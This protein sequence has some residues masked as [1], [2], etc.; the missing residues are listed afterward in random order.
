MLANRPQ[1]LNQCVASIGLRAQSRPLVIEPLSELS[2]L[3]GRLGCLDQAQRITWSQSE[4]VRTES[5]GSQHYLLGSRLG[6]AYHRRT[7]GH[8]PHRLTQLYFVVDPLGALKRKP[9]GLQAIASRAVTFAAEE[10]QR[11]IVRGQYQLH[12]LQPGK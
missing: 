8:R 5:K 2:G 7:L 11:P 9:T 12:F 10:F 1:G 3:I 6:I 4:A